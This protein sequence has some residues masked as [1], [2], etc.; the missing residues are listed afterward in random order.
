[1]KGEGLKKSWPKVPFASLRLPTDAGPVVATRVIVVSLGQAPLGSLRV[2]W[3][4]VKG[5]PHRHQHR[6]IWCREEFDPPPSPPRTHGGFATV[7]TIGRDCGVVGAGGW[8]G[9]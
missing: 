7:P 2:G 8:Y 4:P 1:M 6:Q 5:P 9:K 3:S